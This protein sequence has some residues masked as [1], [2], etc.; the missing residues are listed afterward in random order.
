MSKKPCSN[1]QLQSI[2]FAFET[3]GNKTWRNKLKKK[4]E[5]WHGSAKNNAKKMC[6]LEEDSTNKTNLF[7]DVLDGLED[8]MKENE[9]NEADLQETN[10]HLE[11]E[12][13]VQKKKDKK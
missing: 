9:M 5:K 1:A 2:T 12:I 6:D 7:L 13:T 4:I 8:A 11:S 3:A 10:K